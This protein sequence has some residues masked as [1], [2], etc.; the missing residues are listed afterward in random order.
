MMLADA[1]QYHPPED[2]KTHDDDTAEIM[3][4]D[5]LIEMADTL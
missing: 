3:T 2:R 1:P 5:E 4:D